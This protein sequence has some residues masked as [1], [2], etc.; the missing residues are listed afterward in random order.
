MLKQGGLMKSYSVKQVADLL[1]TNPETVRRWIRSGKLAAQQDSRK[2]GNIIYESALQEFVKSTPKYAGT[3]A[4]LLFGT[5]ALS[6]AL[7]GGL[8]A[9]KVSFEEQ[10]KKA[11]ISSDSISNFIVTEIEAITSSITNKKKAIRHLESEIES[12]SKKIEELKELLKTLSTLSDV[13]VKDE[14]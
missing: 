13:E 3:T 6:T 14:K 10:L 8:V 4:A 12:E 2:G 7:I 1:K 9:Q 11:Q 5:A